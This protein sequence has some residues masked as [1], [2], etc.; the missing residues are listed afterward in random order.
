MTDQRVF[1]SYY[2]NYSAIRSEDG[3]TTTREFHGGD[4]ANDYLQDLVAN[5]TLEAIRNFTDPASKGKPFL[6]VNSW[7]APHGPLHA[8]PWAEDLFPNIT[9]PPTPNYNASS[10]YQQTKHWLLRQ[11]SPINDDLA[12]QIDLAHRRRQQ[13][14]QSVDRHI[15]QFVKLLDER[16][17]LDNTVIIFTSDNGFHFGQHRLISEK[18]HIYESDIRVPFVVRG[19]GIPKGINVSDLTGTV[20]I[21]PTIYKLIYGDSAK[22][23]EFDG[24]PFLPIVPD[25]KKGKKPKRTDYLIDYH[26]NGIPPCGI[27]GG[28]FP[29]GQLVSLVD[30]TS[31]PPCSQLT[32]KPDSFYALD[33]LNNTFKC[34]RRISKAK[35]SDVT[36]CRFEDNENFTEYYDNVRDH[37]QLNNTAKYLST[38]E[39]SFLEQRLVTL[40]NCKG[41][42]CH[43]KPL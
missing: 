37:W 18:L 17:V 38:A 33:S 9:A 29:D 27:L 14:L 25:N 35:K 8:A 11:L 43:L 3:N 1:A 4:Y 31:F 10:V 41:A 28:V 15:D 19:P 22:L 42:S 39:R 16:G 34:L 30:F 40:K 24:I 2:Y 6:I 23:P 20:D 5:R 7:T 32:A 13:T 12:T 21:A 26:G 36:Y